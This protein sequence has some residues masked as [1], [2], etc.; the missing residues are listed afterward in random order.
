MSDQDSGATGAE[1]NPGSTEKPATGEQ[2]TGKPNNQTDDGKGGKAAVLADLATERKKRQ[3]LEKTVADMQRAQQD[4]MAQLA[5][6]FG[7]NPETAS[8]PTGVDALTKQVS[9]IQAQLAASNHKAAILQAAADHKIPA[10]HLGLLESVA[11]DKLAATAEHIGKLVAATAASSQ[12][13]AFATSAG[14]GQG[15]SGTDTPTIQSQIAAAEKELQGKTPGT[16]EH[17]AA[18]R[19]VTTLKNQQLFDSVKSD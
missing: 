1:N 10:E 12:P 14:Q 4:Q 7:V 16:A 8:E 11:P 15:G 18:L 13:P 17:R 5:K 9:E 19:R 3:D 6:A 2:Q